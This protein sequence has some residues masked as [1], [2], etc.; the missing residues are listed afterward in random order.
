MS[1][2][3]AWPRKNTPEGQAERAE[4]VRQ[5]AGLQPADDEVFAVDL[6]RFG[7]AQEM[8]TGVAVIPVGVVGPVLVELRRYERDAGDGQPVEV[9]RA[10]EELHIPLAHT[11][12]G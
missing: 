5:A 2:L 4:L 9:S 8:V 1:G 12:G 10:F 6:E 3:R 7:A 11:E